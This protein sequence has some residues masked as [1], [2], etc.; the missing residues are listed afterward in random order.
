MNQHTSDTVVSP[1][2]NVARGRVVLRWVLV[3]VVAAGIFYMSARTSGD[4]HGGFLGQLKQQ[5]NAWFYGLFGFDYDLAASIAHFGEYLLLGAT[6]V[7]ALRSHLPLSRAVVL[8]VVCAS[9]YGISDEVHQ[10]FVDG[11]YCSAEDWVV[12][13]L[14]AA[15]GAAL[16]RGIIRRVS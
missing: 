12:D 10:L 15:T 1:Q 7:N 5:V 3:L 4:L 13:T 9:A 6:L 2:P 14:G 16:F 11:R 8:A